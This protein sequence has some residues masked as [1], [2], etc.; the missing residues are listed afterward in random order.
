MLNQFSGLKT[1]YNFWNIIFKSDT[2]FQS[3]KELGFS[4]SW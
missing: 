1:V 2:S 4:L 3:D